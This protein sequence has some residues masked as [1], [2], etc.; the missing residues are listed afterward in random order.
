M[1]R[2]AARIPMPRPQHRAADGAWRTR[3][4]QAMQA[5][6]KGDLDTAERLYKKVLGLEVAQPDAMHYLGVLCHQRGR[7]DEAVELI[8]A[9]LEVTPDH[10]DAHNNLG[11]VFKES[12]RLA[13]AETSYR[14][15][16]ACSPDH[17]NARANLAVVLEA[18]NRVGDAF[19][20]Y[21]E[22]LERAPQHAHAHWMLGRALCDQAECVEDMERA[23]QCFRR[24]FELDGRNLAV[25]QHL[26]MTLYAL[27]RKD[28]AREVYRDWLSRDPDNPV[29][30]HMLAACGGAPA[31]TRAGDEYVRN[32]FDRFASSFDQQLLEYL[33]YRAPQVLADALK[34]VLPKA[35]G[36]LDVLDA[37]CGT[38]L[39]G[40]L[41][42][43]HAQ[44]LVGVDLSGGM[45]EKARQ[46]GDYDELAEAEL[47]AYLQQHA[48][49]YDVV[50]S[51]DT[52]VYFGDLVPVLAAAF[53]A[54][55]P[56]GW[57]GFSLEAH[58]G[59]G[60][61]LSASGRYRHARA[62]VEQALHET[63]YVDV[64]IAADSLRK[65][66]GQ[67]VASWV[68]LARRASE[69]QPANMASTG[70]GNPQE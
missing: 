33:D 17:H 51:A 53:A 1:K 64:Q 32:T 69:G 67:P 27:R 38:G 31:P 46:R 12:G 19:A 3:L 18:Q 57:F 61:E 49:A 54:L 6:Q 58:E 48:G 23:V 29:P 66:A 35:T 34:H 37:G 20:T 7:S 63:G 55:R 59:D 21:R 2:A 15:A 5:H 50:A 65:E 36:A 22:L 16:L 14:R 43:R 39:C 4:N 52:L 9:A 26:A 45:L 30:R 47:T 68:V 41:L 40:P 10:P 24:A 44:C 42:R 11:N 70:M 25:L 8:R 56:G 28:E 13:E 62:Y 60:I